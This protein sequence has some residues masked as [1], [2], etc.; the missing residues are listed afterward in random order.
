MRYG[1][2]GEKLGHSFSKQIHETLADYTYEL[3]ELQ[4]NEVETFI[5]QKDFAALNVT[6]P[7]K[8]TVIPYL[9]YIDDKAKEI[10]AVNTIVNRNG[11]LYGYNTDYLGFKYMCNFHNINFNN[12]KVIVIGNGG[13][14]QAIKAAVNEANPKS[15]I[16]VD[17]IKNNECI[18]YEELDKHYD[19]NI[20][21]NT[22]PVG[23][24]P[25]TYKQAIDLINFDQCE[26]VI[27][28]IYNPL[29]TQICVQAK[30]LNMINVNGL[31]MLIAQ[32]KYAVEFF[33]DKTI[34]DKCINDIYT[35]ML[36]DMKNIVLV[37]MPSCGKTTISSLLSKQLNKELIDIDEQIVKTTNSDI[38]TIFK[39]EGETSFRKYEHNCI[40]EVAKQT[41]KI[42]STG[43][44]AILDKTNIDALK[45]NGIVIF[46]DRDL[47]K[48]ISID[49]NRPLLNNSDAITNL[50]INRIELYNNYSDIVIKNN[51]TLEECIEDLMEAYNENI[52]H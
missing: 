52:S 7:Y 24:Y 5:K 40:Q 22:S 17:I 20:I 1:L 31:E 16:I 35:K 30:N 48:L 42:I 23:M 13:A 8:Q 14:A 2:I 41:N 9:D 32:A 12:K 39:L 4:K 6:I 34:E 47:D 15:L 21:I 3:I 11:K 38:P 28:V 37:G 33:L 10:N 18:S 26:A 46:I 50:Y 25:N 29:R 51:G 49:P 19:A 44:G 36:L 43:G 45:M 27:D